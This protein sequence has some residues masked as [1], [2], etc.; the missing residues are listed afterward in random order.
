MN[1]NA[2]SALD[3]K[4]LENSV[5][6]QMEKTIQAFT[7]EL[8]KIRTG[9]ASTSLLDD[10][11]VEAYGSKMKLAEVANVSAPEPRL[12]MVKAFDPTV[13]PEIKKAIETSGLGLNPQNDG[14]LI[15]IPIPALT[16]ERRKDIV[17]LV[18]DKVEDA[19]ISIRNHRQEGITQAKNAQDKLS[20]SKD[21][22][23]RAGEDIQKLTVTYNKKI[24]DIFHA[25]EE[26]ILTL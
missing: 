24:D 18:K 1:I 5:K 15:R 7:A 11:R 9:R 21:E 12:I 25:K 22:V 14:K 13:L 20:W 17:K 6:Q 8:Q 19:R 3:R 26:E 23:F 2:T 4:S 16:E 10:V